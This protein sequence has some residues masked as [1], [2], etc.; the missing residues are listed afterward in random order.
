LQRSASP[1]SKTGDAVQLKSW[2][3]QPLLLLYCIA[4]S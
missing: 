3:R 4:R 1:D 2:Q